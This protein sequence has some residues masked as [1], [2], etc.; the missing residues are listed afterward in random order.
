MERKDLL[1]KK[2][3]KLTV[4]GLVQDPSN[5]N[6]KIWECVCDCGSVRVNRSYALTSGNIQSCGCDRIRKL[7]ESKTKHGMC[8]KSEYRAW[9]SMHE[10]CGKTN[11]ISYKYYGARGITVCERWSDFGKFIDDMGTK[12]SPQHSLDRIDFNKG[13]EPGNCRWTTWSKQNR[14]KRNVRK[15]ELDG[16]MLSLSDLSERCHVPYSALRKRL[17]MGW[18]VETAITKPLE[19]HRRERS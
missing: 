13:Y 1:G 18:D 2:F 7:S 10:R 16:E 14:N 6:R 8:G 5:S 11:H 15:Y 4:I 17:Q 9:A 12:P 3:G 19:V